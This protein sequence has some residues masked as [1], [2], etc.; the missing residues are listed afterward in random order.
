MGDRDAII[1]VAA[2]L[3]L[4]ALVLGRRAAPPSSPARS[5]EPRLTSPDVLLLSWLGATLLVL[6]AEHPMWRPH[7][8]QL[9]PG[10]ALLAA[11]HRPSWR[12][13]AIAGVLV[14]PYH[15]V[16]AWSVLRPDPYQGTAAE[17]VA[18]LEDLPEGA[19]A[20]SDDPGL[21]WRSGRSTPPDLVDAS[22]LRIETGHITSA[23][24]AEVAAQPEVCAVVVR[25]AERWG[26]FDDLPHR[27]DELGYVPAAQDGDVRRV[28]V[29]PDCRP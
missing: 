17:A 8:S 11:R 10:L 7:V 16:H 15:L 12:I 20:I 4:L 29:K 6:L 1:L 5:G 21:V 14:L 24:L 28:Y 13:L 9:V 26:R 23:R 25:S 18:V 3:A 22:V 2:A 19:L 27:L